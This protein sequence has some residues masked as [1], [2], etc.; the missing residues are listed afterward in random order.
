MNEASAKLLKPDE[1]V[2]FWHDAGRNQM[3]T[4]LAK[5]RKVHRRYVTV[6]DT[7]GRT[8]RLAVE[9]IIGTRSESV[10]TDWIAEEQEAKDRVAKCE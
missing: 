5:V 9:S 8:F 2:S 1:V 6:E 3:E 10:W 7:K 4:G